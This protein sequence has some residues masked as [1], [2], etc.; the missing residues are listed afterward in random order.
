[1]EDI[2]KDREQWIIVNPEIASIGMSTA[3][4]DKLEWSVRSTIRIYLVESVLLNISGE[5]TAKNL[6]KSWE[7]C[8]S[9]SRW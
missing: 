7:T 8:I 5:D 1:M 9:L 3:D 6:G 2:L 4:W